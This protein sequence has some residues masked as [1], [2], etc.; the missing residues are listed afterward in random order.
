MMLQYGIDNKQCK[1]D[2]DVPRYKTYYQ[3]QDCNNYM[4]KLFDVCT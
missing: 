1:Q 3:D 2:S 4:S